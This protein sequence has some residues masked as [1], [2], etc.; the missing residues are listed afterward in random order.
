MLPLHITW[1]TIEVKRQSW[2]Y[3]HDNTQGP[4]PL[5]SQFAKRMRFAN[6][7]FKMP[8]N[9]IHTSNVFARIS[10]VYSANEICLPLIASAAF[11]SLFRKVA[12]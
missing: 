5:Q 4:F 2:N 12:F 8:A 9:S 11:V 6:S 3:L 10:I 7:E 1:Y